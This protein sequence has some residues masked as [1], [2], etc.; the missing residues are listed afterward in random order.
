MVVLD[1]NREKRLKELL[2]AME[3]NGHIDLKLINEALIHPSYIYDSGNGAKEHNQRLEFLGDAVLG[4]IVAKYLFQKY[5][6]KTEGELTRL[7]AA[8]VCEASLANAAKSLGL[9]DYLLL[10]KGEE[11]MGGARRAS[12]LAD[13]FEAFTAALYLS[14]GFTLAREFVLKSLKERIKD[15][16]SGKISDYKTQLQ[17]YIQRKPENSLTYK[18]LS[19]EGPDHQKKFFAAVYLNEEELAQGCGRTKKSAE[20]KAAKLAL[21]NLRE[22]S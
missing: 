21:N 8:T 20:Q 1:E 6:E 10:G 7:R 4:L 18:I 19:E 16:V 5:P 15:A 12:N 13:C 14:S 22:S 9:G 11:N 17:E 3:I 2:L